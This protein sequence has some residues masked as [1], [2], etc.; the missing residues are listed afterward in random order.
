MKGFYL[1]VNGVP[2][3]VYKNA[4]YHGPCD[5]CGGKFGSHDAADV[6]DISFFNTEKEAEY[7]IPGWAG[8]S[9]ESITIGKESHE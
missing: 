9:I 1:V 6:G 3:H 5:I 2:Q 4:G 8:S 7:F